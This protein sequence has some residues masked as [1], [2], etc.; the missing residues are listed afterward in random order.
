M[1]DLF[2]Q[3]QSTKNHWKAWIPQVET[4]NSKLKRWQDW[5]LHF[6]ASKTFGQEIAKLPRYLT[7]SPVNILHKITLPTIIVKKKK[8]VAS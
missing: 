8:W 2:E 1:E 7:I 6:R 3:L 4:D 5:D